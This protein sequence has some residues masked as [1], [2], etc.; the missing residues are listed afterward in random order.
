MSVLIR[1]EETVNVTKAGR[2]MTTVPVRVQES[3][4]LVNVFQTPT[5]RFVA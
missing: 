2:D 4:N 5:P 3:F 1:P